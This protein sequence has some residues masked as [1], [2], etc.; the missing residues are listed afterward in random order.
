MFAQY[1]PFM[2]NEDGNTEDIFQQIKAM[3]V[4]FEDDEVWES[5][6]DEAKDLM[7]KMICREQDR[8]TSE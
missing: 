3:E 1:P 5:V 7:S 4:D 8:L 2:E 6:S